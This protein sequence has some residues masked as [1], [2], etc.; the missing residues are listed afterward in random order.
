MRGDGDTDT[1]ILQ[2][3]SWGSVIQYAELPEGTRVTYHEEQ[4]TSGRG[5]GSSPRSHA[6]INLQVA[7][8]KARASYCTK[9]N[10]NNCFEKCP[11]LKDKLLRQREKVEKHKARNNFYFEKTATCVLETLYSRIFP[12]PKI[13]AK[14][15]RCLLASS[16]DW[17]KNLGLT[18]LYQDRNQRILH[19]SYTTWKPPFKSQWSHTEMSAFFQLRI[20]IIFWR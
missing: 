3:P 18:F 5:G 15:T 2:H 19:I 8:G 10:I 12:T 4:L 14:F 6:T 7:D 16:S 11:I 1:S 17:S 20:I 9:S 13:A